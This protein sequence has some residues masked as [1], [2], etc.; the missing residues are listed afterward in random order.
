V[1]VLPPIQLGE[2]AMTGEIEVRAATA[3]ITSHARGAETLVDEVERRGDPVLLVCLD[4][5]RH[6]HGGT[7]ADVLHVPLVSAG[8][9]ASLIA[10]ARSPRRALHAAV[11]LRTADALVR[12]LTAL[13]L[14]RVLSS[15]GIAEVTGVDAQSS[16]I[17]A[18][19]GELTVLTPPDLSELSVDWSRLGATRIGVR[20]VSKRINSI[21][22]EVSL[23]GGARVVAK[24]QRAHGGVAATERA[25]HEHAVLSSLAHSMAEEALTVPRVLLFDAER[26]TVVMERARG[27]A[28]DAQFAEA[29]RDRHRMPML[30]DGL[31]GAGAWLAAMQSA[32][33]RSFDGRA[34]LA[35]VVEMARDDVSAVAKRDRILRGGRTLI[36]ATLESLQRR[37]SVRPLLVAGHHDDYWPGNVFFDGDRV[38]VIDFESFRDG[39]GL[40]DAAFFLIRADLLRRRFRLRIPDLAARFFAGYGDD[41]DPDAL[42]LFTITKGLRSLARRAGEDLP[43]PQRLWTRRTIRNAVLRALRHA[44]PWAG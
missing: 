5:A 25:A 6:D 27:V 22:A 42:R 14:A 11:R 26:A 21:A 38:T 34:V 29:A 31:R 40:E 28:L 32:T 4:G 1:D 30:L 24:H 41:P 20:W 9:I 18:A 23:D 7:L 3:V 8:M 36:L 35:E 16:A 43:L 12:L 39:L 10:H 44:H 19:I 2:R 13:H 15:R 37:V 17:A 33:A